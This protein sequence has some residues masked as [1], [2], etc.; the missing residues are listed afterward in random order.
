MRILSLTAY[1]PPEAYSSSYLGTD[2]NA[3]FTK[4]GHEVVI[5]TPTPTRGISDEVRQEYKKRRHETM[6]DGKMVVHRFSLMGER[7][8][9]ILRAMRYTIS[10]IKQLYFGIFGKDARKCDVMFI[11]STPPIQGAMAALI[12]KLRGIPYIYNLQDIFPDSLVGTGMTH[13]GSILWKIGRIIENFTY[14]NAEKIIVISEDF[15]QNLLEK[16]VPESK[17]EVIYNWVDEKAVVPIKKED[18]T[19][20]E[21][22]GISRDKFNIVYAGNFGHA[23][24][25]EVI[26]KAA[27]KLQSHTDIRFL[28]F[29]TGGLKEEFMEV[30]HKMKLGNVDFYPLQPYDKVSNVYSLADVGIVSC[31]KG[32]GKGAMPSKTWSILSAATAVVANYDKGTD[33]EK[34]L[35]DNKIGLFSDA[36]D[37][38]AFA[39]A[40]MTLYNDRSLCED[41]GRRGRQFI[42]N[43]LTKEI[44]TSKIIRL[45]EQIKANIE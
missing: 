13:K 4:A 31:K 34:I 9:P 3:A 44:G 12:K 35:T 19:L 29:G 38:D 28:L 17:I 16:G 22:L 20:Y 11:S 15:K 7:K 18:N 8:N 41:M 45:V 36:D 37:V 32:I 21:E 43:N 30:A 25:I 27:E 24:N 39:E 23:Q 33:I 26:L 1:F 14:R 40:I 10:C 5:Y 6:Y 42:E 2:R